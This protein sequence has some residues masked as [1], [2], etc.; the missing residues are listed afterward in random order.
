M[1]MCNTCST[2][3]ELDCFYRH[4]HGSQGRQTKCKECMTAYEQDPLVKAR[5]N[6]RLRKSRSTKMSTRAGLMRH[7]SIKGAKQR[8][9]EYTLT[10]AWY[11][12]RLD[13]GVCEVTGIPFVL[14]PDTCKHT[15]ITKRDRR[16]NPFSP[17]VD[18]RDSTKGYTEDN[19]I[20]TCYM[21]NLCKQSFTDEAI[22]IFAEKFLENNK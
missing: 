16:L 14:D 21:Y 1:K 7:S 10:K 4:P 5:R 22:V 18:R 6:E 15:S 8:G 17:S 3:K 11:K 2:E 9:L 12:E 20:M 19:C 13:A